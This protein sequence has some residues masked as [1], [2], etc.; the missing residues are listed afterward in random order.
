MASIFNR[1]GTLYAQFFS[2]D[3][4]PTR[5]RFSRRTS[6]SHEAERKLSELER[7]YGRGEFDPW[8]DDP[9]NYEEPERRSLPLSQAVERFIQKKGG[10]F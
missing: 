1:N 7:A 10:A 6:N 8:E 3:R 9:F 2:S 4:D 5:K